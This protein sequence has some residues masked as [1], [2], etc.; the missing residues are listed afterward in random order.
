MKDLP[1]PSPDGGAPGIRKKNGEK[2][3]GFG[4]W[5]HLFFC[6]NAK[7]GEVKRYNT[8][9]DTGKYHEAM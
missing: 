2:G 1:V 7:N 9:D 6:R 3:P 5:H 4:L 8:A